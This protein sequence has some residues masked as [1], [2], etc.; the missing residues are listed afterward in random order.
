MSDQQRR[1]HV[2]A[3]R[4][5]GST[6]PIRR[7]DYEGACRICGLFVCLH[8]ESDDSRDASHDSYT[9]NGSVQE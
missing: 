7:V 8:R 6:R 2:F 4:S 5:A 9:H 1:D 3:G